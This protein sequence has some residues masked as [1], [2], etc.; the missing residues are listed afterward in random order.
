MPAIIYSDV[1]NKVGSQHWFQ[2]GKVHRDNDMPAII[3]TNGT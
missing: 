1:F 2:N 3:Y